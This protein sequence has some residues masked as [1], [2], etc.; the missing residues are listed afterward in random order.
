[1]SLTNA[2]TFQTSAE[3]Q[4]AYLDSLV[5]SGAILPIPQSIIDR[6]GNKIVTSD[7][8]WIFPTGANTQYTNFKID[9]PILR[10]SLLSFSMTRA[11]RVSSS[12][13]KNALVEVPNLLKKAPSYEHLTAAP[14]LESYRSTLVLVMQELADQLQRAKT[15][16]RYW[17]PV[18][19]YKWG[20]TRTADLGFDKRFAQ[21]VN[22]MR[23]PGGPKGVAVRSNDPLRGPLDHELER[24]LLQLSLLNDESTKHRH[25]QQKLAIALTLAFGRNS[26]SL[27]T[28]FEEDFKPSSHPL[29][30]PNGSLSI[31]LIKKRNCPR[32][33]FQ[34]VITT[35]YLSNLIRQVI[36]SNEEIFPAKDNAQYGR[37]L[38]MLRHPRRQ[39][40]ETNNQ[41]F[42]LCFRSGD[43]NELLVE[44]V[45]RHKITSPIT[46]ELLHINPRRMR[47]TFATDMVD[48][49]ISKAE[50]AVALGHSDTQSVRVYYDIGSRIVP[51]LKNASAGGIEPILE[52]FGACGKSYGQQD[53]SHNKSPKPLPVPLSCYLCP[54]FKPY[55]EVDHARILRAL[56]AAFPETTTVANDSNQATTLVKESIKRLIAST[57]RRG[58]GNE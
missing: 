7:N 33:S 26:L 50:L 23:I 10:Y 55:A 29:S 30:D 38:F 11:I 56:E 44:F 49:G 13:G 8:R 34:T 37:P 42:A 12:A 46:G 48:M 14:D 17:F 16:S 45:R 2:T 58:C 22:T 57:T 43:F 5:Q 25:L 54:A 31:P 52:M 3:W 9:C 19:W 35:P 20:A 27:R 28:L 24:P 21:R 47:Y 4:A 53:I 36:K 18:A 41:Q 51:H 15:Y 1:M 6:D 40:L 39:V 32:T